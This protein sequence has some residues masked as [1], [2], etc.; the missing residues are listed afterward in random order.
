MS[1]ETSVCQ[2]A[3]L[4]GLPAGRAQDNVLV[5]SCKQSGGNSVRGDRLP[6]EIVG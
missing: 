3:V 1:A 6:M 5:W 4:A 2:A